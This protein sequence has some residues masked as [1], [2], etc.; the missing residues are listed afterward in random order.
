MKISSPKALTAAAALFLLAGALLV[1]ISRFDGPAD[2]VGSQSGSGGPYSD[3]AAAPPQERPQAPEL[4]WRDGG[5]GAHGLKELR[6]KVVLLNLWATWCGPCITEMPELDALAG[7]LEGDHFAVVA[8]AINQ[9]AEQAD[10][11]LTRADLHHL[12]AFTG[13]AGDFALIGL[14]TTLLIDAAGR[15]A[16]RGLGRRNWSAP[17]AESILRQLIVEPGP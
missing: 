7:R 16:W 3:I 4:V 1:V 13:K 8:V 14:P 5:D 9:S 2:I 17:E 11:F 15:V 6:G 10:K 12:S